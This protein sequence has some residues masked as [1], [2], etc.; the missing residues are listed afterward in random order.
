MRQGLAGGDL[1]LVF[2]DPPYTE[3]LVTP[4]LECLSAA[5]CVRPGGRVVLEHDRGEILPDACDPF[6][7]ETARR[8]GNTV[9]DIYVRTDDPRGAAPP[10]APAERA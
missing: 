8:F 3:R 1:G 4:L 2:A 6:A 9:V 7:R 10:D 5:G